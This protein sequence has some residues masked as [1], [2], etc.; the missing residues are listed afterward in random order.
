MSGTK[1]ALKAAKAALDANKYQDAIDQ[2]ETVLKTDPKNYH[3]YIF[4]Q[5]TPIPSEVG[6][7]LPSPVMYS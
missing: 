7:T 2:A 1:A 4:A 5:I 6:L 3:A